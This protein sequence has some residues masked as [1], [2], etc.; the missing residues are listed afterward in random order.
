MLATSQSGLRKQ[1]LATMKVLVFSLGDLFLALRLEGVQKVMKMPQIF[2]SGDKFLG[3]TQWEGKDVLVLDLYRHIYGTPAAQDK[4]HLIIVR[5]TTTFFGLAVDTVP[6]MVDIPLAEIC[7]VSAEF[8]NRDTLGI[9][10]SM[11]QVALG[12][13]EKQMAFL[14]D[15]SLLLQLANTVQAEV[16]QIEP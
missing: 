5:T 16:S 8:R 13:Q 15:F 11:V 3:I 10:E 6:T 9:A 7:P 14:L 12:K 4:G 2:K 1:H